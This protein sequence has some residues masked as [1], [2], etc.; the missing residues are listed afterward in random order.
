M[1]LRVY[2]EYLFFSGLIRKKLLETCSILTKT[3]FLGM[4]GFW[5]GDPGRAP[6]II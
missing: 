5:T 2:H 4:H 6:Y 1:L 3:A